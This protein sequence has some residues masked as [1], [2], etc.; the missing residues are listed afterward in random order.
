[1]QGFELKFNVY[2]ETPEEVEEAR[3]AIVTFISQHAQCG[4]A[5]TAKKI[6]NAVS[7]WQSNPIVKNSLIKYFS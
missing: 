4:R 1:M 7:N 2:A 6:A 3:K 5:V